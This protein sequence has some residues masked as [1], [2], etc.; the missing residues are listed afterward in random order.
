MLSLHFSLFIGVKDCYMHTGA[1]E[2]TPKHKIENPPSNETENLT[3]SNQSEAS[4][5]NQAESQSYSENCIT[6]FPILSFSDIEAYDFLESFNTGGQNECPITYVN[7]KELVST[8]VKTPENQLNSYP[9]KDNKEA[10]EEQDVP[11]QLL[12]V[13]KQQEDI[14]NNSLQNSLTTN[15]NIVSNP[16]KTYPITVSDSPKVEQQQKP[17][18]TNKT[19]ESGKIWQHFINTKD[20]KAKVIVIP[21]HQNQMPSESDGSSYYSVI[22]A[23]SSGMSSNSSRKHCIKTPLDNKATFAQHRTYSRTQIPTTQKEKSKKT[24][25]QITNEN[26]SKINI[27]DL[28]H[29]RKL[30]NNRMYNLYFLFKINQFFNIFLTPRLL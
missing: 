18:Q 17:Q 9:K 28:L 14:E 27:R 12:T 8:S 1:A 29:L 25:S 16:P 7:P 13:E 2:V 30:R 4:T 11:K 21:T 10:L 23:N 3:S 22:P 5:D 15:A 19:Q 20:D 6:S 24:S 26:G